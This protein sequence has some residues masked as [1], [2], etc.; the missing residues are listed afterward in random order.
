MNLCLWVWAIAFC[1]QYPWM[2]LGVTLAA[3]YVVF[4]KKY[5]HLHE[6]HLASLG[7]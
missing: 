4:M 7:K 6:E 5:Y 1:F 3:A 2:L